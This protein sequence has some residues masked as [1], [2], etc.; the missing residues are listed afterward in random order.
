MAKKQFNS[1]PQWTEK[2]IL[3]LGATSNV[4]TVTPNDSTDLPNPGLVR[5]GTGGDLRV[6]DVNGNTVTISNLADGEFTGVI[7]KRV[8]STSTT[9]T[10]L[11]V[12]Y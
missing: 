11:T 5:A 10:D 8:Y 1:G 7:V 3:N 4:A 12:Y 2:Q 6:M 9:A